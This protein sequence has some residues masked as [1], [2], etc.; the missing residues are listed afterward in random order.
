MLGTKI[1]AIH[2]WNYVGEH[3]IKSKLQHGRGWYTNKED[4]TVLEGFS[5]NGVLFF[6]FTCGNWSDLIKQTL[7]LPSIE[8]IY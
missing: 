4:G 8:Y 2:G 7:D 1:S 3:L 5:Y 6:L